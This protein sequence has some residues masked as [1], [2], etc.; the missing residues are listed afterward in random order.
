MNRCP[1]SPTRGQWSSAV[2]V[3]RG[4][5]GGR[6]GAGA[7]EAAGEGAAAAAAA[8]AARQRREGEAVPACLT[9]CPREHTHLCQHRRH[10]IPPGVSF[11][12]S[13]V[14]A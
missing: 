5:G 13:Q 3:T 14:L 8:A 7:A 10:C 2:R 4:A 6:G 1:P 9:A 11:V 12:Q